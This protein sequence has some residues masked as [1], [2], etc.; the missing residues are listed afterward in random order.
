MLFCKSSAVWRRRSP[1]GVSSTCRA[2]KRGVT[3]AVMV[4]STRIEPSLPT[5]MSVT[6][7][8]G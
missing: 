6:I 1:I 8:C 2:G 3:V 7:R 4:R 5:R